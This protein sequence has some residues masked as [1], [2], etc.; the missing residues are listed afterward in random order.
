MTNINRG[1]DEHGRPGQLID[2]G[3]GDGRITRMAA[4]RGQ[5][6][7]S[8]GVEINRWLIYYSRILAISAG[9]SSSTK[10][11]KCDLWKHDFAQYSNVIIFGVEPMMADLK[12]KLFQVN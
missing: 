4:S 12:T 2:I 10:F 1:L 11:I 8:W 3:S 5:F 9:Q 6:E 7:K